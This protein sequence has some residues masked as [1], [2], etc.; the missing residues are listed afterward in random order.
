MERV[1]TEP[2]TYPLLQRRTNEGPSRPAR[3]CNDFIRYMLPE[4]S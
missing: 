4:L 2:T 3:L 1:A